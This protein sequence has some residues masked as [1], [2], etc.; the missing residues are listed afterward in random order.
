MQYD[1]CATQWG[2]DGLFSLDESSIYGNDNIDAFADSVV[3][4]FTWSNRRPTPWISFFSD[5]DHAKNWTLHLYNHDEK[6]FTLL[7]VDTSR[8]AAVLIFRLETLQQQLSLRT[9]DGALTHLPG[10][11]VALLSSPSSVVI[12]VETRAEIGNGE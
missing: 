8:C 6:D 1:E 9:P 11:Y 2:D 4:Q 3:R 7:T 5:R 12:S 10:C